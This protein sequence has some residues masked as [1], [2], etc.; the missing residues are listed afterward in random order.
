[1]TKNEAL[2]RVAAKLALNTAEHI[3]SA[4]HLPNLK[5]NTAEVAHLNRQASL[6]LGFNNEYEYA[7]GILSA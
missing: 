2:K 3:R 5:D 4:K 6:A 7:L 1:M